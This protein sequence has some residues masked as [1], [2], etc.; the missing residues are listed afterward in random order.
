M[1]TRFPSVNIGQ[2]KWIGPGGLKAL[3]ARTYP[4]LQNLSKLKAKDVREAWKSS[5]TEAAQLHA[6]VDDY[7]EA[8]A[9]TSKDPCGRFR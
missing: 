7:I 3:V 1:R 9:V 2:L 6:L 8:L 5:R 4:K